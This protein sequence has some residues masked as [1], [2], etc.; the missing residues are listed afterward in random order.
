MFE[1]TKDDRELLRAS[2]QGNSKAFGV[3]V[4]RYQS[5][6]CAITYSTTGSV[7]RSE[8]LA[9]EVFLR[10][11][12]SLSQLQDLSRFRAWLS[13]I[14]RSTVLNWHRDRERDVVSR[15]APLDWAADKASDE[16]GPEEAAMI[17]E[18]KAVV[19]QALAGIPESLREP[20][21]L[22]YRE[23]MSI[24]E[25]ARQFD[26]TENAA[27]QRIARGRSLLRRQVARMVETTIA[28]TRPG[29][30]FTTAVLVCIVGTAGKS[31]AAVAVVGAASAAGKSAGVASLLSGATTKIAAIAAG[32]ALVT[33]GFLAYRQFVKSAE[34]ASAA[35]TISEESP[36][37][38]APGVHLAAVGTSHTA[39]LFP[40]TCSRWVG[41]E[42]A[43]QRARTGQRGH[44]ADVY[45]HVR[46]LWPTRLWGAV[47]ARCGAI[48]AAA[49]ERVTG[50]SHRRS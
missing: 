43:N 26:L 39:L 44:L 21:I 31:S 18:Q 50:L 15:A 11:W 6:V 34:P 13:S 10:A 40:S 45:T 38:A 47:S 33:A 32:L 2:L 42:E 23:Q 28:R 27:R 30:A 22:Y 16:S 49:C 37:E 5:L 7:E 12:R 25:V 1:R 24:P 41:H 3:L 9:Q 8:E 48:R 4:S 46:L 35:A 17:Q 29:K 36:A 20:L 19:Q 14:A